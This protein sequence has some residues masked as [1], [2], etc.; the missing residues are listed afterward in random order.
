MEMQLVTPRKPVNWLKTT[1]R[2]HW[3]S[4]HS[5]LLLTVL[6]VLSLLLISV[7]SDVFARGSLPPIV[8]FLESVLPASYLLTLRSL[9]LCAFPLFL[10]VP[11]N[12]A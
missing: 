12:V 6:C 10:F 2:A 3:M 5:G 9:C 1:Q 7:I 8:T 4:V 11:L